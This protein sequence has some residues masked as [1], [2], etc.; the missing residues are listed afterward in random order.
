[1]QQAGRGHFSSQC[2]SNTVAMISAS[3]EQPPTNHSNQSE[4]LKYLDTVENSDGN[5]SELEL[6]SG[7]DII[8]FKVDTG[9]EVTVLQYSP[10]ITSHTRGIF[11][12]APRNFFRGKTENYAWHGELQCVEKGFATP[13]NSHAWQSKPLPRMANIKVMPRTVTH[14]EET[15]YTHCLEAYVYRN[16]N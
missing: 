16:I 10:F 7:Q 9:A 3:V 5:I 6:R 11:S 2:L 8:K 1:M 12:M 13:R 15:Y 4:D 14:D